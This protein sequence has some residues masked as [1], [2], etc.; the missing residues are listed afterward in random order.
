MWLLA[1]EVAEIIEGKPRALLD[2]DPHHFS[3]E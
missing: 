2:S 3:A 1:A